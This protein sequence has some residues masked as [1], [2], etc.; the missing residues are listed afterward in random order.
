MRRDLDTDL[1]RTFVAVV[2]MNGF[3]RASESLNRTQSAVSMQIKRLE[4]L[5]KAELFV[6]SNKGLQLTPEGD[7]LLDYARRLVAL[8]DEAVAALLD[9]KVQGVVRFGMMEDYATD[10]MPQILKRFMA[11]HPKVYI[12]VH[13]GLSANMLPM[14]GRQY[15]LVLA[16]HAEGAG[17]GEVV[18]KERP[19]WACSREMDLDRFD[20]VPVA[21]YPWD[22]VFREWAMAAL[23]RCGRPWRAAFHSAAISAV[24]AA[25]KEGIA[26]GVFK[27]RTLSADLRV[28]G[29]GDGFPDL[30]TADIVLYR[31]PAKRSKAAA[32]LGDFVMEHL[33]K[34]PGDRGPMPA[35]VRAVAV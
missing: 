16:M 1:L 6:R 10:V 20:E 14:L 24:R 22:C 2:D 27:R 12:E 18:C 26:V 17:N 9:R 15:D 11:L 4:G 28:L 23:D 30:P 3:T 19:V 34:A 5:M 35:A 25:V 8:N 21:L 32:A 13:S 7:Q 29:P 31:S 33:G